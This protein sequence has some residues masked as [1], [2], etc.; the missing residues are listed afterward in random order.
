MNVTKVLVQQEAYKMYDNNL[1]IFEY[2]DYIEILN[3]FLRE[4]GLDGYIHSMKN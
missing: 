3:C 4:H 2:Q 1:I